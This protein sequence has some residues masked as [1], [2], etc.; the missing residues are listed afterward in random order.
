M[1]ENIAL[2]SGYFSVDASLSLYHVFGHEYS[3]KRTYSGVKT[4]K[5]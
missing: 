2:G 4:I 3:L 1:G 5:E